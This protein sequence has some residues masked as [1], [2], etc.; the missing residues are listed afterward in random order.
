MAEINENPEP[1]PNF[2]GY[3][4]GGVKFCPKSLQIQEGTTSVNL[5]KREA[6]FL[7]YL[8][9]KY[10]DPASREELEAVIWQGTYVNN[11]TINQTAKNTRNALGD[12]NRDIIKTIPKIGYQLTVKPEFLEAP[13]SEI[14]YNDNLLKKQSRNVVNEKK[15]ESARQKRNE[16]F[17]AT[18]FD[19][20]QMS[21]TGEISHLYKRKSHFINWL[22]GTNALVVGVITGLL[23]SMTPNFE[24]NF[25][26]TPK[27]NALSKE[28]LTS[29]D[30]EVGEIVLY[31]TPQKQLLVC[32]QKDSVSEIQCSRVT[33]Y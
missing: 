5:R 3:N 9:E 32:L 13:L 23:L 30:T 7:S 22:I 4:L 8:I 31:R 24:N 17:D 15:N 19:N 12:S 33:E 20:S 6:D 16:Y 25:I 11:C 18:D 1:R 29:M 28:K 2:F 21:S 26:E 27:L 10:P 14:F